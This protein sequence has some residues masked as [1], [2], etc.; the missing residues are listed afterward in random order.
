M[1]QQMSQ[2]TAAVNTTRTAPTQERQVTFQSRERSRSQE[3]TRDKSQDRSRERSQDRQPTNRGQQNW[4]NTPKRKCRYCGSVRCYGTNNCPARNGQ[5]NVCGRTGHFA[6]VCRFRY[7]QYRT[8][9]PNVYRNY[10]SYGPNPNYA[11]QGQNPH[12]G[13]QKYHGY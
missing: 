6:P 9:Q 8:N 7:Q 4:Q 13:P 3:R 10:R 2:L 11:Y 5:C 1:R 12:M